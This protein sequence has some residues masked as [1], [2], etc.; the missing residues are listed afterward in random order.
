MFAS[1]KSFFPNVFFLLKSFAVNLRNFPNL[2]CLLEFLTEVMKQFL[3]LTFMFVFY[4]SIFLHWL[5]GNDENYFALAK[6]FVIALR[7]VGLTT[8]VALFFRRSLTEKVHINLC[9]VRRDGFAVVK[10]TAVWAS[11]FAVPMFY[12]DKSFLNK[13]CFRKKKKINGTDEFI[14]VIGKYTNTFQ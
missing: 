10:W 14:S 6:V 12:E 9:S 5:Q 2:V 7:T 1:I 4:F 13:S 3:K 11:F 8:D